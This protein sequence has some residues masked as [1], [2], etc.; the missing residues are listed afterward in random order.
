MMLHG[1]IPLL[2]LTS[3]DV[4]ILHQLGLPGTVSHLTGDPGHTRVSLDQY[5][6]DRRAGVAAIVELIFPPYEVAGL[7]LHIIHRD[8]SLLKWMD[9]TTTR[10]TDRDVQLVLA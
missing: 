5:C 10:L 3:L 2:G 1:P 8:I 4:L 7:D 6:F 9:V